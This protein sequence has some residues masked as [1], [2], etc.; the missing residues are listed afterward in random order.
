[1]AVS[2]EFGAAVDFIESVFEAEY[3]HGLACIEMLT[4]AYAQS[5]IKWDK[6]EAKE[7][8]RALRRKY[9]Y[10]PALQNVD[11]RPPFKISKPD[12]SE[13]A[14]LT[15]KSN[16]T[17]SAFSTRSPSTRARHMVRRGA[18]WSPASRTKK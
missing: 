17:A 14:F 2:E 9:L 15:Y 5:P 10:V 7:K 12:E 3:Q 8:Q 4:E 16:L 1:M 13:A 18:S 11:L 6:A